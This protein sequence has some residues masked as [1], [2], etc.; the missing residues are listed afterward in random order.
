MK[1]L[2]VLCFIS[3]VHA[4]TIKEES[5]EK[6]ALFLIPIL[7]IVVR[8]PPIINRVVQQVIQDIVQQVVHQKEFQSIVQ[9]VRV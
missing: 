7:Q 6:H 8:P 5:K 9:P 4:Q 1:F 3:I 2:C